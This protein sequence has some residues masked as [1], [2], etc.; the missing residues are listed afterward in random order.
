MRQAFWRGPLMARRRP[1]EE[2]TTRI[3]RLCFD[4]HIV[5]PG[6]ST[7]P[8]TLPQECFVRL[9][10]STRFDEERGSLGLYLYGMMRNLV[11]QRQ[12]ASGREVEWRDEPKDDPMCTVPSP[13]DPGAS[14]ELSAAVQA[15]I[16]ALPPLQREAIVLCEFEELSLDE[17]A[18]IVRTD[19]GT[20]KSR[21]HRAREGLRRRLAA[22]RGHVQMPLP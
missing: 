11:R 18:A 12:Q 3:M 14:A 19:I 13:A 10:V 6:P 21:L 4:L 1:S 20:I 8:R 16:S 22:Y 5:S 2:S 15:A 17:A 7:S 9:M